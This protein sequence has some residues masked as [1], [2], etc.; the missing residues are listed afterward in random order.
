M[1]NKEALSA[2]SKSTKPFIIEAEWFETN[3][4]TFYYI[5]F[6]MDSLRLSP[7]ADKVHI[8]IQV[9]PTPFKIIF[10]SIL[11]GPKQYILV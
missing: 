11:A 10:N 4:P 5:C 7:K 6:L 1:G 9:G 8:Y 2:H 3:L